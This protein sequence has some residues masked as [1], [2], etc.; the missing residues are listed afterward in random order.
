MKHIL[1][2]SVLCCIHQLF[3]QCPPVANT[4]TTNENQASENNVSADDHVDL[5]D[6]RTGHWEYSPE[7][8]NTPQGIQIGFGVQDVVSSMITFY[9]ERGKNSTAHN[10]W[11][12]HG[13]YGYTEISYRFNTRLPFTIGLNGSWTKRWKNTQDYEALPPEQAPQDI[14]N[15]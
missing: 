10:D 13:N 1:L 15:P 6:I 2:L 7:K 14:F 11:N 12:N 4:N 5:H 3:A 9:P 8:Q